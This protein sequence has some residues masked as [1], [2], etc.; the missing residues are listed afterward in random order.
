M[1]DTLFGVDVINIKSVFSTNSDKI[2][3]VYLFIIG[4]A[5]TLLKTKKI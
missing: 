3:C 2:Q 4:N 5:N 1:L